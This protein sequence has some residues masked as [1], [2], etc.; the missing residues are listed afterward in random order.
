MDAA[1]KRLEESNFMTAV[2]VVVHRLS[3]LVIFGMASSARCS[4][5][6]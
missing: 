5:V 6:Q 2:G 3:E 4:D 1:I